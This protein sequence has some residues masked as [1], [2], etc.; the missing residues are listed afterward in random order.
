LQA[1]GI[2]AT[3]LYSIPPRVAL[4]ADNSPRW[5][6]AD[7]GIMRSGAV[8]VVR[9]SQAG[10]EELLFILRHSGALALVV[11]DIALL[12]KIRAGATALPSQF[13]ILLSRVISI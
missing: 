5:F 11:Q 7:Q 1:L 10:R 3:L 9:G 8:N 12:N 6:I 4:F 2:Q 13:V